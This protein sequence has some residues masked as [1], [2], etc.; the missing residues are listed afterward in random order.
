MFT[1][2]PILVTC[3]R[4]YLYLTVSGFFSVL[5]AF[6]M[7]IQDRYLLSALAQRPKMDS[8]KGR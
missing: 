8:T 1:Y 6:L 7:I 2:L 4:I 3:Y 5:L